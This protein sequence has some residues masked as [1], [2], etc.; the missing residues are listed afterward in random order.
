MTAKK[1]ITVGEVDVVVYRKN[2]QD[3]ISLT[4]V[5]R[6][7]DKERSNYIIQNWLRTRNALEFC[8][9]W[10][11]TNNPGFNC[12]EFDAIKTETGSNSFSITPQKWTKLTNAVGIHS[13]TG[14][15]GSGTFAHKDIAFEFGSWL[16]PE[17]KFYLIR[18]F[19]RLKEEESLR[20][21]QSWNLQRTLAKINYRIHTDAIKENLVPA[22]LS[23]AQVSAVYSNEA[24]L[25]NMALYGMTAREWR[26][27][28]PNE[29][30]NVRDHST[31]EQL[32]VLSN[33]ESLNAV[34]IGQHLSS[35][36]RLFQLNC[37]AIMQ[38]KSLLKSGLRDSL[39]NENGLTV[40]EGQGEYRVAS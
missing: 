30:G 36:E 21:N 7:R 16:S 5:A 26:D 22:E 18:E 25:L 15:Y 32:I 39:E 34:F 24:D 10:E 40:E 17:F 28:F 2:E 38:M 29:K 11:K 8:G 9:L 23:K 4:D 1:K 37:A 33:L 27:A 14:R 12:I 6:F 3:Y 35:S 31:I 20:L 19:Q 13:K